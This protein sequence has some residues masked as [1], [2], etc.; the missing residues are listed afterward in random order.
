MIFAK[1]ISRNSSILLG[2][3]MAL[4]SGMATDV[5]WKLPSGN[6]GHGSLHGSPILF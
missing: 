1:M 3:M 2:S 6:H 4:S 5:V